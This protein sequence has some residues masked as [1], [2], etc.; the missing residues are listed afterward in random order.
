MAQLSQFS[1]VTY[2]RQAGHWRAAITPNKPTGIFI[3]GKTISGF[4]TP[5]DCPSESDA[6]LAAERMIQKL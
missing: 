3:R 4:V 1:I 6:K 5:D 2:E